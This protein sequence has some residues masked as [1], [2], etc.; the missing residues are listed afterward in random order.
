MGPTKN[1]NGNL[2]NIYLPYL[3]YYLLKKYEYFLQLYLH[4]YL[5]KNFV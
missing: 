3:S 5:L 4:T 2:G 1:M